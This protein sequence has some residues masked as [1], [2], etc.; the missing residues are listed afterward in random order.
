M[1]PTIFLQLAD[2]LGSSTQSMYLVGFL[3]FI[4]VQNGDDSKI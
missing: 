4:F 3:N 2:L 1:K